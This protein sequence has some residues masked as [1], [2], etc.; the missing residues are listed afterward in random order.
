M[1]DKST[2]DN[3]IKN[4][5]SIEINEPE[6]CL[7]SK[8]YSL[9]SRDRNGFWQSG[10]KIEKIV[11]KNKLRT[12]KAEDD[13]DDGK[14]RIRVKFTKIPDYEFTQ[15]TDHILN[16]SIL[17]VHVEGIDCEYSVGKG[18]PFDGTYDKFSDTIVLDESG[19]IQYKRN[20]KPSN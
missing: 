3:V 4:D 18:N 19:K 9:E 10:D 12:I 17:P 7:F 6:E 5:S 1:A 14:I 16:D 20:M 11:I 8:Q 2:N 13:Y 15:V